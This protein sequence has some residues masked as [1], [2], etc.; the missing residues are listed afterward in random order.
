[1]GG[2][3]KRIT[4]VIN[5]EPVSMPRAWLKV[6]QGFSRV[7]SGV[8]GTRAAAYK[9]GILR[10]KRLPCPVISVGNISVGGTGKT[11]MVI[12]LARRIQKLGY[13]AVILSRGYKGEFEKRGGV[14]S[15]GVSLLAGAASAGDEPFMMARTLKGIPVITGHD[16]YRSGLL[17][18]KQFNLDLILLDDGFQHL[19]LSR[20]LN[21]VLMDAKQPLGNRYLL[22]RGNLREP[23]GALSRADAVVL[24]RFEEAYRP[25]LPDL[26]RLLGNCPVFVCR[27][28]P[29]L[30]TP[31][32]SKNAKGQI[33]DRGLGA[34]STDEV[35]HKRVL[36]FSGLAR[37][38][39]FQKTL[40]EFPFDVA[41]F[42]GFADHHPYSSKDLATIRDLARGVKADMLCT[43]EKDFVRIPREAL[44]DQA[45][46]IIGVDI[47]FAEDSFDTF[48]IGKLR[49][50]LAQP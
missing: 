13:R 37:N 33:L 40:A 44:E 35:A 42:K 23:I 26:E 17:A 32:L 8:V 12:Y 34:I 3:K 25:G 14:V 28:Q 18:L 47:A 49:E 43:T 11:P 10:S 48:F 7:Y 20:D 46:L 30:F 38:D 36:G 5:C 31:A 50:I 15:D 19:Q 16:R 1:M 24:T 27:H 22:P 2:L 29:T 39:L 6:L 21:I 9:Q 45:F 4:A 41:G